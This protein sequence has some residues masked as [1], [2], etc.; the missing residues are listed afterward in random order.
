LLAAAL[1]AA[2][3]GTAACGESQRK[4]SAAEIAQVRS[5]AQKATL[6]VEAVHSVCKDGEIEVSIRPNARTQ[7]STCTT[8]RNA[9]QAVRRLLAA[10]AHP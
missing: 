4:L 6:A 10:E 5:T 3:L 7:R 8:P 1:T 2:A 9:P